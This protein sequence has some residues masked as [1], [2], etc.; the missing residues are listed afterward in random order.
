[1]RT[2]LTEI[3]VRNA[4]PPERGQTT[5]WDKTLP[6]FGLRISQGGTKSWTV[7]AGADRQLVTIGRYPIITLAAA[8][9][10]AKRILAERVLGKRHAP[11][12]T[13]G[14]AFENFLSAAA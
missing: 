2:M 8:R 12:I 4:K 1:M 5:L 13:F 7:M 3:V 11:S 14:S 6:G 9:V 10:E